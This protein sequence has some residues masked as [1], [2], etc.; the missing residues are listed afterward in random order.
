MPVQAIPGVGKVTLR[1]HN[2]KG[3]YRIG[4]ITKHP[5]DYFAAAFGKY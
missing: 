1:D 2:S 5:Q 4:D 3:I